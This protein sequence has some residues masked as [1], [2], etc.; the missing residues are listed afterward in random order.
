LEIQVNGN[1]V[2]FKEFDQE[3]RRILG[4]VEPQQDI[5]DKPSPEDWAEFMELD[6]DFQE[7]GASTSKWGPRT[8]GFCACF[9]KR[10]RDANG[11]PIG[12]AHDNPIH[13]SR[14]YEV[15]YQDGHKSAM[16]ANAIAQNLFAQVDAEGNCHVLFDEIIDHRTDGEEV[17]QQDAFLTTRSGTQ[18]RRETTMGWEILVQWKDQSTSWIA[19]KDMNPFQFSWPSILYAQEFPKSLHLLGGCRSFSRSETELLLKQVELLG[20]NPQVRHSCT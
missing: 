14:M 18:R 4:E 7:L 17:K 2:L 15:D 9:T 12:T 13:D 8:A 10:L 11:L 5:G 6:E 1:K 3:V 19:F 20:S 16:A